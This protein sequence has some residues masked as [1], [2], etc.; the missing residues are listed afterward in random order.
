MDAN[1]QKIQQALALCGYYP[2]EADGVTGPNTKKAVRKFQES[3]GLG[4]DGIAGPNTKK[5]LSAA[6]GGAIAKATNLM[7]ELAS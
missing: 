5:A 4:A 6:L 3:Q 2:G 1:T 7:T